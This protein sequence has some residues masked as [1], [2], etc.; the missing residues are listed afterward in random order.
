MNEKAKNIPFKIKLAGQVIEVYPFTA[1]LLSFCRDYLVEDK[2]CEPAFSIRITADDIEKER[3]LSDSRGQAK[4][5]NNGSGDSKSPGSEADLETLALARKAADALLDFDTVLFHG[6][7]IAFDGQGC[8]FAASSGVG[9][10]THAALWRSQFGDRVQYIN[11]DKPFIRVTDEGVSVFGSPWRG[12]HGLGENTEIPLRVI[13]L[14]QRD[15]RN[16]I[17]PISPD[18]AY[19]FIFGQ[20]YRPKEKGSIEK[21]LLLVGR[22]TEQVRLFSLGCNMDPEAA[23]TACEGMRKEGAL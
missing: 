9:K 21:L 6:S 4:G 20:T 14:L 10:S 16:H 19:P 17:E 11:D 5:E 3:E 15:D 18:E 13:C 8:C 23:V 22:L 2:N 7:C 1:S 12:V